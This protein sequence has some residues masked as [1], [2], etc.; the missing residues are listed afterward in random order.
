MKQL[1]AYIGNIKRKKAG[2]IGCKTKLYVV[3]KMRRK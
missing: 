2:E 1:M 3:N